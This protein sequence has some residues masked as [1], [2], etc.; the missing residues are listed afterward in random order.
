M[1]HFSNYGCV[2]IEILQHRFE[3]PPS[4]PGGKLLHPL[5]TFYTTFHWCSS[6]SCIFP[7][8]SNMVLFCGIYPP[9][10]PQMSPMW[11]ARG[12]MIFVRHTTQ[13][14]YFQKNMGHPPDTI[15]W[16]LQQFRQK[17]SARGGSKITTL[18]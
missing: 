14:D 8:T 1:A 17:S 15:L 6:R 18:K 3:R 11:T 2:K 5:W 12:K 16:K 4:L 9:H 10:G 13:S 7:P